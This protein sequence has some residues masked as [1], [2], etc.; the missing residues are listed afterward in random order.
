MRLLTNMTFWQCPFWVERTDCLY[1]LK[2]LTADPMLQ[3]FWKEAWQL[4]RRARDYDV[5]LTMGARESLVYGLLCALTGRPSR[6]VM[7]EVFLDPPRPESPLW[8]VKTALFRLVARRAIGLITNSTAEVEFA[9]ERLVLPRSRIRFVPL[10][11]TLTQIGATDQDEGYILAA[12]RSRRDY[13]TLLKAVEKVEA[14]LTILCG[15]EDLPGGVG[16]PRVVIRRDVAREEYLDRLGRCAV[17]V[18]PLQPAW[19][20]TGQ[21]VALEAMGLGKC[22][23]ATRAAGTTDY[24]RHGKNGFLVEPGDAQGWT[25]ILCQLMADK[26]LRERVGRQALDD[27]QRRHS[28]EAHAR[29]RLAAIE[30]LVG[31]A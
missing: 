6:Q 30:E 15:R 2:G 29:A 11:C 25:D 17:A 14:P 18:V 20:S 4:F 21:V 3:P 13:A 19:R 7:T 31:L 27:V 26:S 8:C 9:V 23:V 10:Q 16:N 12:G 5:V 24:I 1:D 28:P 22:V